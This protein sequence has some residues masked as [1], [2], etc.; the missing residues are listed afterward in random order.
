MICTH[1]YKALLRMQRQAL[2]VSYT[3]STSCTS[4]HRNSH[5]HTCYDA[6]DM[7]TIAC[8]HRHPPANIDTRLCIIAKALYGISRLALGVSYTSPTMMHITIIETRRCLIDKALR[9]I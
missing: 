4:D 9:R 6:V 1:C 8:E 3:S 7:G 5:L 2:G